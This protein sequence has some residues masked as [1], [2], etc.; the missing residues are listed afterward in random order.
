MQKH[1]AK[2]SKHDFFFFFKLLLARWREAWVR[3][4]DEGKKMESAVSGAI[5]CYVME[6]Q[7][8]E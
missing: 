5:W 2:K 1:L 8:K 4:D 7:V 3:F 6:G